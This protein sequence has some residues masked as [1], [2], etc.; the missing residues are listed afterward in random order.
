MKTSEVVEV[1]LSYVGK[2]EKPNNSGFNDSVFQKKMEEV[3]WVKSYAWCSYFAELVYRESAC[4]AAVRKI[5]TKLFSG[6][7]T[8]TFKNFDL[9]KTYKTG[10]EPKVG[11]LAIWRHGNGWQGHAAVVV[12][13]N[14][15]NNTF[16]TVEGNTNDAGGREGYIVAK[17]HRYIKKPFQ[18]KGLNLVGFVYLT[19]D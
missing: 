1:A 13:V 8:T 4:D 18:P 14:K 11:A 3:G 5:L 9:D 6:S 19:N 16:G 12:S 15:P 17:K 7:A 10:I 2:T